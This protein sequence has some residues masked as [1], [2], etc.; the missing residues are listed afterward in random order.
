MAPVRDTHRELQARME[1]FSAHGATAAGGIH[2]PE[3]TPANGAARQALVDW[4]SE[5]GFEV[6]VD[7]IGNIFGLLRLAGANAPW[8]MTGSHIDS[9]P[10]GGRFDGTYGVVASTIAALSV[11]DRLA[12]R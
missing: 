5:A 6:R 12:A 11:R 1:A 2:R 8:L 7:S 4:L 10:N 3:A 9:Q